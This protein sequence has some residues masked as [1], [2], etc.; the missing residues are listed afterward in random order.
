MLSRK[1]FIIFSTCCFITVCLFF[2]LSRYVIVQQE[3]RVEN[4]RAEAIEIN[5]TDVI[6]KRRININKYLGWG[7]EFNSK[8]RHW[9][10]KNGFDASLSIDS[11]GRRVIPIKNLSKRSKFLIFIGGSYVMSDSVDDNETYAYHL[12]NRFP[13]YH[14]YVYGGWWYAPT[15]HLRR[16]QNIPLQNEISQ[17]E[18]IAI[19]LFNSSH[20]R[21][22]IGDICFTVHDTNINAPKYSVVNNRL[23]YQ[24]TFNELN[25][26]QTR[27]IKLLPRTFKAS[28]MNYCWGRLLNDEFG[29]YG[30][31]ETLDNE[32]MKLIIAVFKELEGVIKSS[33]DK[34]R[35]I[36]IL[37]SYG[38]QFIKDLYQKA[39]I[40]GVDVY[41]L[42]GM[43]LKEFEYPQ[44]YHYSPEGEKLMSELIS[45]ILLKNK[46][47]DVLENERR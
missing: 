40:A 34:S 47:I 6:K 18:G 8:R 25:S 13:S 10:Y 24:G 36:V 32:E 2:A 35:L 17:D 19:L 37:H 33:F 21:G 7:F 29:L 39:K 20:A 44:I 45:E 3:D 43:A 1:S 28:M 41:K 14:P 9:S 42:D 5:E 16:F 11:Y 22:V 27:I 38:F 15:Q 46:I 4:Y 26:L 31:H 12:A 30:S 23:E